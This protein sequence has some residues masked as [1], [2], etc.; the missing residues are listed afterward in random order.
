VQDSGSSK[1][2][3]HHTLKRE[4]QTPNQLQPSPAVSATNMRL[5]S[6]HQ[7]SAGERQEQ[8]TVSETKRQGKATDTQPAPAIPIGCQRHNMSLT[9]THLQGVDEQKQQTVHHTK[10][11]GS[12]QTQPAL[13]NKATGT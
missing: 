10:T 8:S 6:T 11:L 12:C 7:Q 1:Q 4:L 13:A 3:Q 2:R 9:S 5:A